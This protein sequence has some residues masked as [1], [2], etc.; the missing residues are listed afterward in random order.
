MLGTWLAARRAGEV[1]RLLAL[2][3]FFR[4]HRR[5]ACPVAVAALRFAYGC[6]LLPDLVDRNGY[7]YTALAQYLRLAADVRA[8]PGTGPRRIAVVL[9]AGDQAVDRATAFA[10]PAA[11]AAAGGSSF[12]E[13]LLP[14]A[15]GLSHD[16]A[17]PAA[18]GVHRDDLYARYL[19][20]YEAAPSTAHRPGIEPGPIG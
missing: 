1:R 4:P 3:P 12:E 8:R 2:A 13:V 19:G 7:S 6:R 20:L 16:I 17:S 14:A 11:L 9:S 18:L 10:L 5:H 15:M